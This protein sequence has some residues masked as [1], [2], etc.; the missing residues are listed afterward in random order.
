MYHEKERAE[1]ALSD[2]FLAMK[3][4][5]DAPSSILFYFLVK[6]CKLFGEKPE[7]HQLFPDCSFL[8]LSIQEF[9]AYPFHSTYY[10]TYMG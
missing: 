3:K 2:F 5:R 7:F 10:Y 1:S 4:G 8:L 9:F 6:S